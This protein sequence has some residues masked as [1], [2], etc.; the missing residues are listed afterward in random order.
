VPVD[1]TTAHAYDLF[2]VQNSTVTP[3]ISISAK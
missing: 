3:D 1:F 2:H